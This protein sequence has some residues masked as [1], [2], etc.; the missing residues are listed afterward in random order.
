VCFPEVP[1]RFL[2]VPYR[3]TAP[4][5]LLFLQARSSSKESSEVSLRPPAL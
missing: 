2:E 3:R 4:L 5:Y 1:E